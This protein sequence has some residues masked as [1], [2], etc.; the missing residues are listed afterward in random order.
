M[1]KK[2]KVYFTITGLHYYYGTGVISPGTKV[3]LHK[4]P[5]NEYDSEAIRVEMKGLGKIGYDANSPHTVLGESYSAGR[6]YG[7]MGKKGKGKVVA[8]S[9]RGAIA[10]LKENGGFY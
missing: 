1:S 6:M 3:R 5:K 7:L 10:V 8:V 2:K 4:E 9:E